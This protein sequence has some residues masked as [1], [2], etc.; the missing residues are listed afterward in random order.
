MVLG[1]TALLLFSAWSEEDS[2]CREDAVSM[3]SGGGLVGPSLLQE[4]H[5]PSSASPASPQP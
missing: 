5:D 2:R 4:I 3:V 1:G